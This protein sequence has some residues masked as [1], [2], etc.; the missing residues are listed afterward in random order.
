ME[1]TEESAEEFAEE[2]EEGSADKFADEFAEGSAEG[3]APFAARVFGRRAYNAARTNPESRDPTS[4]PGGPYTA[5]SGSI[6][7]QIRKVV[8]L[9]A[10]PA[11]D[12]LP[13]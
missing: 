4:R 6:T 5:N 1:S 9:R 12:H 8:G 13:N 2:F 7:C 11:G 3:S 10:S